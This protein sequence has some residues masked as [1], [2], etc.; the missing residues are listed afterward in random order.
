MCIL[1]VIPLILSSFTESEMVMISTFIF[2]LI[3]V[4]LAVP[5][6]ITA[7][8]TSGAYTALLQL[9]DYQKETKKIKE[10]ISSSYWGIVVALYLAV[11]FI[12]GSWHTTW[13]IW[14]IAGIIFAVII[15]TLQ[16]I[17]KYRKKSL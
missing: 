1:A 9:E 11:S 5:L 14:P 4:S 12:T 7:G 8:M 3:I 13:I 17:Q 15:N 2:L 16:S 6:F 10:M